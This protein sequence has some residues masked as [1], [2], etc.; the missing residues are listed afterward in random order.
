MTSSY[1]RWEDFE[2]GNTGETDGWGIMFKPSETATKLVEREVELIQ[3]L[4]MENPPG[5]S[6]EDMLRLFVN[7][8]PRSR[9]QNMPVV[10]KA[11]LKVTLGDDFRQNDQVD[12]QS[13]T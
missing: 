1:N 2:L 8:L 5:D 7:N 12:F 13:S 4:S 6:I 10:L 9:F 11:Q 3:L